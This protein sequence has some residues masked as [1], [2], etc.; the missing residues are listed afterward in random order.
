MSLVFGNGSYTR[1]A[2]NPQTGQMTNTSGKQGQDWQ[3]SNPSQPFAPQQSQQPQAKQSGGMDMSAYK[4]GQAQPVQPQSQ[5]TA[6]QPYVNQSGQQFSGTQSY[7]PGTS[8]QYQNE[9]YGGW[10]NSQGY[11]QP[12]QYFNSPAGN[13]A[14]DPSG[15]RPPP[16]TQS[17]VGVNG[18]QFSD[19]S[20]AFAQRDALIQRL[21]DAKSQYA[22][23][24]GVYQGEGAPPPS[25]GQRPQ[26]DFG[27]LTQQASQMVQQGWQNPFAPP[28]DPRISRRDG[29]LATA[30]DERLAPPQYTPPM[31]ASSG[32]RPD[33]PPPPS[34]GIWMDP[35]AKPGKADW[36]RNPPPRV[37]D[38]E[39][40]QQLLRGI[41]PDALKAAQPKPAA[42]QPPQDQRFNQWLS[43]TPGYVH[44]DTPQM[45]SLFQYQQDPLAALRRAGFRI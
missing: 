8:E 44:Q 16:Y 17:A 32:Y 25:W 15:Y 13:M 29:A 41:G 39:R 12:S 6:Y 19:P 14:N 28:P 43:R 18:Q 24:A 35:P 11:S 40:R 1:N 2:V 37:S 30:P 33:V 42:P 4:P 20:Q 31:S 10:A 34:R 9:A 21:N 27:Q 3:W 23:N 7:A 5:G 36:M 38:E 26:Y 45:R 22:A